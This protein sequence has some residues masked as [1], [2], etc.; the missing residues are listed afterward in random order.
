MEV[1]LFCYRIL[2]SPA[3]QAVSSSIRSM[4]N[5]GSHR[6]FMA[7]DMSFMGLSSAATRLEWSTPQRLQRWMIAHSPPFAPRRPRV[8]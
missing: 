1:S 4:G 2:P 8:P 7:I 6:G 5:G 3:I